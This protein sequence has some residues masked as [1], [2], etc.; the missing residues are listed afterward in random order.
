MTSKMNSKPKLY[1]IYD[2]MCSWCWG[3]APTWHKLK[4]ALEESGITVKYKLGGLAPDSDEPMPEEMQVFLEQT[5]HKISAQLGTV[6]NYD[7]WQQ[8]Q[9]RRS[10]YPA[11][12]AAL[13]A[14]EHNLEQAM[15]QGIQTAYYLEAKNPSDLETLTDIAISIGLDSTEFIKQM[16]SEKLNQKLMSEIASTRQLPIQ[17]FPS[18]VLVHNNQVTPIQINYQNWQASYQDI[19][20]KS[21][22][23]SS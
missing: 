12:R 10:T 21:V 11:C 22:M 23:R 6:F 15:L 16:H 2:P 13:I 19:I 20:S 17:G 1:Y 8:C 3:Y 9:P 5:W 7:F 4:T 18:L 14:R